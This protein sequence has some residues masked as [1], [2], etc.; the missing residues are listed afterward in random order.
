VAPNVSSLGTKDGVREQEVARH[1]YGE[2][3]EEGDKDN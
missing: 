1:K 3:T 2:N